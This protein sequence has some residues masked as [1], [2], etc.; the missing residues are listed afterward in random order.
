MRAIGEAQ[1]LWLALMQNIPSRI[2]S[3]MEVDKHGNCIAVGAWESASD[4]RPVGPHPVAFRTS[5]WQRA[6]GS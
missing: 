2:R 4:R 5:P 1:C 6:V 3:A